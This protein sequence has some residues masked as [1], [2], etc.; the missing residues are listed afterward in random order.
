[1]ARPKRDA[2]VKSVESL[3]PERQAIALKERELI[4][5]INAVLNRIGYQ[6][7]GVNAGAARKRGGRRGHPLG[8]GRKGGSRQPPKARAKRRGRRREV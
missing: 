3:I 8:R 7:V 4:T 1:M 2:L 5:K 6:V